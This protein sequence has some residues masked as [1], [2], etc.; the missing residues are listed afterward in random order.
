METKVTQGIAISVK[1]EYQPLHSSPSQEY[2][3]FSY[4]VR[5]ENHSPYTVQLKRRKW[6]ITDSNGE[7]RTVDGDGVVGSHPVL[8]PGE[9]FEYES[10]CNFKTEIGKMHGY[11]VMERVVDQQ[12]II[13]GIPEFRLTVPYLLN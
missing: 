2:F 10:C 9:F 5:I 12:E 3:L 1:T 13:V 8:E 7:H 4:N 6:Y 11:Y